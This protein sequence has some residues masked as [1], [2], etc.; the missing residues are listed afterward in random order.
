[1]GA[2]QQ[3][4]A[5]AVTLLEESI[6][7]SARLNSPEEARGHH[8]LAV[9]MYTI[10]DVPQA[11]SEIEAAIASGERFGLAPLSRFSRA[12]L[13]GYYFRTG[14]WDEALDLANALITDAGRDESPRIIRAWM[15]ALRGELAGA[16]EDA[17]TAL[18]DA[19]RA[20]D[21]QGM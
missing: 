8:N 9:C 20:G 10:G 11:M 14:R 15:R 1:M 16:A 7:L 6:R 2:V 4:T 18:A 19:R 12:Q 13:P 5:E 3:G 21:P 17:E